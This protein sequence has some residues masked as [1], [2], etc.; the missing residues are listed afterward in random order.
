MH[1][2]MHCDHHWSFDKREEDDDEGGY[3]MMGGPINSPRNIECFRQARQ[4]GM[5]RYD[6]A[7][8][9]DKDYH[10]DVRGFDPLTIRIIKKCGYTAINSDD[11][12]LCYRD[13]IHLH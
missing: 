3:A 1:P 10:R 7:A 2:D 13:I 11:I 6:M 12:L 8:L 4:R 5:S 9:A